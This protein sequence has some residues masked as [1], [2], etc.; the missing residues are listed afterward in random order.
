M[1][2]EDHYYEVLSGKGNI[3]GEL[4]GGC[5]DVFPMII[6]AE[7]WPEHDEWKNKILLVEESLRMNSSMRS[8]KK[9]IGLC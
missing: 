6:G 5:L 4:L 3:I 2:L 7:V 9:C 1:R 8:I